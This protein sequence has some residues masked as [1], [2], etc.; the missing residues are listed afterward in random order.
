MQFTRI[1]S[2]A[3]PPFRAHSGDAGWDLFSTTETV[4]PPLSKAIIHTGIKLINIPEHHYARIAP[5]SGLAVKS[6]ITVNA[7]VVD[8]EYRGEI[9][10]C[11]VN[12]SNSN[13]FT[14]NIG[15]KIAQMIITRID[16][17]S[18]MT[19]VTNEEYDHLDILNQSS[20]GEDGFGST[21]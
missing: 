8:R 10:V 5:R 4:I 7:G 6:D 20:R 11:L 13:S 21:G 19:E 3:T 2:N 17:T 9:L 12:L 15:D 14:V 1:D 18:N 16:N